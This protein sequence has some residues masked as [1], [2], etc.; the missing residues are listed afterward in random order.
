[1]YECM[2]KERKEIIPEVETKVQTENQVGKMKGL[3]EKCLGEKRKSF[4]RERSKRN[5]K[6][7]R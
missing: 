3:R 2:I 1:M 4:C 5:E 7:S 6:K